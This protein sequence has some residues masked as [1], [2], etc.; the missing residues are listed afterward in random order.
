MVPLPPTP[1]YQSSP[2]RGLDPTPMDPHRILS[3]LMG[4]NMEQRRLRFRQFRYQEAS[5]PR[6]ACWTL[7]E[8]SRLWLRPETRSKEQILE[9]LVLE[10]FLSILPEQIQSWVWVR[11]PQSCAQ[12]VGWRRVI[13]KGG[14]NRC[15]WRWR[16]RW[17]WR[18]E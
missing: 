3:P 7:K 17:R 10:Q 14:R 1:P 18:W 12:A 4:P 9:L 16:W 11:H 15:E 2:L 13:P 5:G 6:A 8:L